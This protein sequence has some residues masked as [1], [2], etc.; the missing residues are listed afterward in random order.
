MAHGRADAATCRLVD[1]LQGTKEDGPP[2]VHTV[3]LQPLGQGHNFDR[4]LSERWDVLGQNW[5]SWPSAMVSYIGGAL[6]GM[7]YSPSAYIAGHIGRTTT[8]YTVRNL[9]PGRLRA[10]LGRV[11]QTSFNGR[12]EGRDP[13]VVRMPI[14]MFLR[15]EIVHFDAQIGKAVKAAF[16]A[17]AFE[18]TTLALAWINLDLWLMRAAGMGEALSWRDRHSIHRGERVCDLHTFKHPREYFGVIMTRASSENNMIDRYDKAL[19]WL[20]LSRA[21]GDHCLKMHDLFLDYLFQYLP[22]KRSLPFSSIVGRVIS[23][24]YI[25][26]EPSIRFADLDIIWALDRTIVLFTDGV[27]NLVDG[28]LMCTSKVS[29][30]ADPAKIVSALQ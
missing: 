26:A 14:T 9:L 1:A 29:S 2:T 24:P 17:R 20:S 12:L 8:E 30:A 7:F 21:I 10:G 23:P 28:S 19:G 16:F 6:Y 13:K 11:I 25:S 22:S 18:G 4:L 5:L 27:D 3:T 15:H